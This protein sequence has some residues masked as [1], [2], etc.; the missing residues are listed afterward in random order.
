LTVKGGFS[1]HVTA[2]AEKG[3]FNQLLEILA[4]GIDR[5]KRGASGSE[6]S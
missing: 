2:E 1:R 3:N 4:D 6:S 5:F